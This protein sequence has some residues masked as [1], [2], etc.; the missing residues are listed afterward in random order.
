[1]VE[2]HFPASAPPVD[3]RP[4]LGASAFAFLV[5]AGIVLAQ[6]AG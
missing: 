5:L 2:P 3:R 4:A 6:T 1:M